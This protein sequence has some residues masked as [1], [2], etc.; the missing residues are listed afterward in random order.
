MKGK[1]RR[2]ASLVEL[3]ICLL[4]MTVLAIFAISPSNMSKITDD[5]LKDFGMI[6]DTT[7]AQ[8]CQFHGGSYPDTLDTLEN[9]AILSEKYPLSKLNYTVRADRLAYRLVVTLSNGSWI[10]PGSK[11]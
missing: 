5:S 3:S 11:Y 10:T 1:K 8:W 4:L 6:M 2:G 9:L 7:L